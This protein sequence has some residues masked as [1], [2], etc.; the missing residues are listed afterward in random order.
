MPPTRKGQK[1]EQLLNMSAKELSRLEVMQGLEEKRLKHKEAAEMLGIGVRPV[2]RLLRAYRCSGAP[3]LVSKRCGRASHNQLDAKVKR[4]ALD[5]LS[6]KYHGFGPTL[7]SEKL[8]GVEGLK[9]S[10][11]SVRCLMIAA[12]LWKARKARKLFVHQNAGTAYLFWR[13]GPDRWIAAGLDFVTTQTGPGT[14]HGATLGV[15]A[16]FLEFHYPLLRPLTHWKEMECSVA[17]LDDLACMKLSAIA[18]RG[19]RKDF[20]DIYVLGTKHRPLQEL[21]GLY[22]RKFKVK[23]I[24]PVLYGLSYFDDA[25]NEPMPRMLMDVQWRT[26]KKTIQDWVK[27]LSRL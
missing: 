17:S 21:L 26:I 24:G 19:Q 27:E 18:Q 11:E 6:G 25:D 23:D 20:C 5:L 16:T 7:A 15:R 10:G 3:G 13:V 9:I 1:V 4:K 2:K 22:Q 8:V 12:D 14:L